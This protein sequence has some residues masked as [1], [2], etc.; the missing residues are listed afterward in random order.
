MVDVSSLRRL[1]VTV[2]SG[3]LGAGKT[4]LLNHILNNREGR[5]VAVIVNDMSEVNIDA[6]LVRAGG[7]EMSRT[8]ERLV[9]MTNGCICCTLRDDLL[10]E[11]RRLAEDGRFDYLL[12]EGTGIA[13]PLPIAATFDFR[14]EDGAS[15]SDVARLDTMVTVVDAVNLLTDYDS[16][17]FLRDR[18][19]TAGEEDARTLVD[20]LVEQI[21]FADVV[22]VNKVDD[23]TA[24]ERAR[25]IQVVRGLNA[26]ARIVPASHGRV[27]LAE[28]LETGLYS[29]ERSQ[30]HPLWYRELF[31]FAKH[32]PETEEYGIRS[33]VFRARR[34]LHPRK[35][36]DLVARGF[37]GV[38]RA[39]GH[40]WIASRP[41]W[42]GELSIAGRITRTEGLG[43][44]WAAVPKARWPTS[45]EFASLMRRHWTPSW[46]DRR[47][48]IV[49][50]G[51]PDMDE[52]AI[53]AAL[54]PCLVGSVTTGL[55]KSQKWLD[56]PFPV[57][58]Q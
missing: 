17:D 7:G 41:D 32:V 47:Q 53:R 29:E 37:P 27:P 13:E 19:E 24:E 56:D 30:T 58:G 55:T 49:F 46:G 6:D 38:I 20:L 15:L 35:F 8:E 25:V 21:E 50:I 2:L 5:R 9:E 39:K 43:A 36:H 33:F 34:P 14:G 52:A 31:D 3:F 1:P 4:T 40:F 45:E 57:W 23:V 26:D 22:V 18:G 42:I 28:V 16:R 51:G 12:I 44:W 48:E 10:A 54:D 11:V